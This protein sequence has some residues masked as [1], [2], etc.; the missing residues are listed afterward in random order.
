MILAPQNAKRLLLS[1]HENIMRYEQE[2]G[3]IG[4]PQQ[5]ESKTIAP[6]GVAKKRSIK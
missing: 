6:F 3:V 1:L 5:P 4:E 2:F